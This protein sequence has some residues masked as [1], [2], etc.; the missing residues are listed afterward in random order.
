[1]NGTDAGITFIELRSQCVLDLERQVV[2]GR[3]LCVYDLGYM[4]LDN[5]LQFL[6]LSF[7]EMRPQTSLCVVMVA[8]WK[9]TK[10]T[11]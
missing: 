10:T 7:Q 11:S 4:T 2:A 5:M 3:D 9:L 1:M 6:F 8:L